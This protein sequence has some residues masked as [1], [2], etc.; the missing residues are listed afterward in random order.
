MHDVHPELVAP[1]AQT[2]SSTNSDQAGSTSPTAAESATSLA[3]WFEAASRKVSEATAIRYHRYYIM[4]VNRAARSKDMDPDFVTPADLVREI[5]TDPTL[6]SSTK[7][8]YRAVIV[9]A[10]DQSTFEFD[11]QVRAD[12]IKAVQAFYPRLSRSREQVPGLVERNS[13]ARGRSIPEADLGPLLNALLSAKS[14]KMNWARRT[15]AWLSAGIAT[16][17]RPG[18]WETAYWLDRDNRILRV[19]NLK[20]KKHPPF[21]WTHI[22]ARLLTRAETDLMEMLEADPDNAAAVLD[23]AQRQKAFIARNMSF[24]DQLETQTDV[25]NL[26]ALDTLHRLRAWELHNQELAWR[27]IEVPY[28]W[29]NAVDTQVSN[30]RDFLA[31]DVE[32]TFERMFNGCRTAL[33]AACKRAFPDGRLYSLYDTRSTASANMQATIG[34]DVASMV[35]GHYM[36]RRRSI[37]HYAGQDRAF[38]RAGKFAP[39]LAKTQAQDLPAERPDEG[40]TEQPSDQTSPAESMPRPGE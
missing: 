2:P 38:R 19:P 25:A 33:A 31:E 14:S 11:P 17:A 1:G 4:L 37:K 35:L 16:G 36:Q 30:V 10:L 27:D 26:E 9:W 29:A 23:A 20:L 32:N 24:F 13:R 39:K 40:Q 6:K 28:R 21:S 15:T 3:D 22:P 7:N 8:T 5:D 34:A 18:E 12:G